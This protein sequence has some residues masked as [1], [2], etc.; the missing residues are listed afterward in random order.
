MF[1][2]PLFAEERQARIVE[3][4]GQRHKLL[5]PELC[6]YFT[7]SPATIRNDL[8]E[9]EERGLLKRTHGGAIS[10]VGTGYEQNSQQK[11]VKNR[12]LKE[13]VAARAAE[14]VKD[15]DTI[16]I[17]TG[18]TMEAFA[19]R[20]AQKR[21]L[22]VVTNDC[23]IASLLEEQS[24]AA[25]ILTGGAL[26][27]GF[28]CTVGPVALETLSGLRVDKTFLATNGLTLESGLT[29]PDMNQAEVKRAMLRI[30]GQRIL[31]CDSTKIGHDSFAR[32]ADIDAVDVLVTDKGIPPEVM[33]ALAEKE[34]Q[35]RIAES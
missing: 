17:D 8:N 29:T 33:L 26:R 9:L 15:G 3:L 34:V 16:A 14:L 1:K 31:L 12:E 35:V 28:H 27:K 20:I 7:V 2:E 10:N 21:S 4:L 6:D 25:V 5:V 32:V 11:A 22:T 19:A 23:R 13:A 18:T 24:D 30:G